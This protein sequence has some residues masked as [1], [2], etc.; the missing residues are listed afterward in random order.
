[1]GVP[2]SLVNP[3]GS[4]RLGFGIESSPMGTSLHRSTPRMPCSRDVPSVGSQWP[5]GKLRSP[6]LVG[7]LVTGKQTVR[8]AGMAQAAQV[9]VA[10]SVNCFKAQIRELVPGLGPADVVVPAIFV[11]VEEKGVSVQMVVGRRDRKERHLLRGL[12][13]TWRG[14]IRAP[15]RPLGCRYTGRIHS[16]KP[17]S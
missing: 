12:G 1:M 16:A 5:I 6:Q 14:N 10:Q 15:A 11:S 7:V 17:P 2:S 4:W 9:Y 13:W 8:T 3:M